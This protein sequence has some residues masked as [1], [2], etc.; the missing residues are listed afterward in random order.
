MTLRF[1]TDGVRGP[2]GAELDGPA[3]RA[4][5]LAAAAHLNT[6]RVVVGRD[7]RQSGV[8][9]MQ[10]LTEGLRAGGLG[11]LSLGVAPTPAVAHMAKLEGAAGAVVSASHNPWTDNGVKLFGHGG[12]KLTDEIQTGVQA[13]WEAFPRTEG[14]IHKPIS[15]DIEDCRWADALVTS[16]PS[17]ALS[18]MRLILDCAN[19]ATTGI[20]A[21]ILARL[22]AD[23]SEIHAHPDGRNINEECGS[24]HPA[25][26]QRA[27]VAAQADAGLAFDGDGDRVVVVAGDGSLLDGDHLLAVCA[28]DRLTRGALPGSTVVVTPMANLG[29]RRCLAAQGIATHEVPVGDRHILEAME[30]GGWVLGGEQSGHLVFGDLATTGDG[31]LT[32]IQALDAAR[33]AGRSLGDLAAELVEQVPQVLLSVR[34]NRPGD[35]VVAEVADDVVVARMELGDGGRVLVRPSGTEPVVRVMVEAL[36]GTVAAAVADRL[37]A[38]IRRRG[39][40]RPMGAGLA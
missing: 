36:D 33:R 1:G 13:D 7:T 35:E 40:H 5:G 10:A 4:L 6:D 38:A 21:T 25:D 27:V 24:T 39:D 19:G 22:D 31:I 23:V 37:C 16:V 3:V 12:R 20:A 9:L 34:V 15:D 2:A 26:L 30:S 11:I 32:G 18:G 14:P 8:E 29:L 17:G 28:L